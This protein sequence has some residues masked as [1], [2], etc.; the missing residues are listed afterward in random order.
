M[1]YRLGWVRITPP[2]FACAQSFF[3]QRQQIRTS[4]AMPIATPTTT[5]RVA[6]GWSCSLPKLMS[7]AP[8]TLRNM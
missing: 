6:T 1:K 8:G 4:T 2:C 3:T 5:I 7:K